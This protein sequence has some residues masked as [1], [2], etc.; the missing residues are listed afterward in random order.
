MT[1]YRNPD[2]IIRA[3]LSEGLEELSDGVYD[4]VRDQLHHN[5]QRVVIGPWR[6]PIM[7]SNTFRVAVAAV[8]VIVIA[9]VGIRF[10]LPGSSSH[11]GPPEATATP[12]PS[13]E[14]S[15]APSGP[16]LLY[17]LPT[18]DLAAG[19]YELSLA[20][21]V[22]LAFTLPEGFNHDRGGIEAIHGTTGLNDGIEFQFASNV[23]PDPCH[24]A[25]GAADPAVGP[26]VDELV[27]AMTTMVGFQAGPVTDL[28]IAGFAAKAFDLTNEI[29]QS[30]C[31]EGDI[32]T[33]V[34]AGD[35][36]P[37]GSSVGSG[38]Q[39]RIY[40]VDVQGARLMIMTYYFA[41][42]GSPAGEAAAATLAAIVDS[43]SRR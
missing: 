12:A 42:P 21:P 25:A 27:A 17:N 34:W 39:Q 1:D 11:G 35:S 29:D 5:R 41:T 6:L 31:D 15:V 8:A 10:L 14:P 26:G 32:R 18:G 24:R 33:F 20:I 36:A 19:T 28:T 9:F 2:Q 22:R 3:F 16:P 43:I 13:V 7:N 37:N 4:S 30:T 38:E 23:Y 40:V